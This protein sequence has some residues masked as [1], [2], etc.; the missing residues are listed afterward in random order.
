MI[1]VERKYGV[2]HCSVLCPGLFCFKVVLS[3]FLVW[4]IFLCPIV[5]GPFDRRLLEQ[6]QCGTGNTW[7]SS[8]GGHWSSLCLISQQNIVLGAQVWGQAACAWVLVALGKS[9]LERWTWNVTHK[10][11]CLNTWSLVDV[12][13]GEFVEPSGGG[14]SLE[15]AG[16]WGLSFR[17]IAG[18]ASC[19]VLAL[20]S[21][22]E[23]TT[24]VP[25]AA[26]V[27]CFPHHS[28][29]PWWSP[30]LQLHELKQT[31]LPPLFFLS[32]IYFVTLMRKMMNSI[33]NHGF[34]KFCPLQLKSKDS[35]VLNWCVTGL[36]LCTVSH[37]WRMLHTLC[38]TTVGSQPSSPPNFI[39]QVF[40]VVCQNI[41]S[42]FNFIENECTLKGVWKEECVH[43]P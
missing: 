9:M 41:M 37:T 33:D 23:Q 10:C 36:S 21:L 12:M 20:D 8:Y 18:L 24:H 2:G 40:Y 7:A 32:S 26:D 25:A 38:M 31:S 16:H 1:K 34:L 15:E 17:F 29:L 5:D 3:I 14:T 43:L 42:T 30:A 13:F 4:K 28:F 39:H 22:G 6:K 11:M 19:V 35:S 27:S